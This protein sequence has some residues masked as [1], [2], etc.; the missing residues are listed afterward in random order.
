LLDGF[1]HPDGLAAFFPKL[2]S[3]QNFMD[4]PKPQ[5]PASETTTPKPENAPAKP[6]LNPEERRKIA[7]RIISIA[8][9][10]GGVVLILWVWR[11]VER[12]PRTDDA[13][14]QANVIGVAPRVHGQIIKLNVQDNQDVTEGDVLFEIDPDDYKLAL[15]NAK[16]ALA[17]LDQQIEVARAQ[18]AELKFQVK[19]AEAGVEQAKAEL[20]QASDTLQRLQPLLPK[21]FATADDVDKAQTAEKVA[22]ASLA[23]QEQRS[24]QAKT[25]LSSLATLLAQRPGTVAAVN[26]AVLDLSYCK[27]VAPFPGKVINLNISVGGYANVGV[28]VFS[29]LDT[30][31][32]YIIANFREGE[33]RHIA[34]GTSV[35]VYLLSAP[36][37]HFV[38]K[39][40]G[41]G[42]A[43]ESKDY[44]DISQG[45]PAVP[46][47]L[48]WV[49]IAQ[50]FPVRIEIENPD[51]EL[52]RMGA[53][54]EAIIKSAPVSH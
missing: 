6:P 27:V 38:G 42:W 30:R 25:S 10:V 32:W 45:V 15:E 53:S 29:L 46:R 16:A 44:I 37:R 36:N 47:E 8:A 4:D 2:K 1:I 24:N 51:P 18:D 23:A 52:F 3:I 34:P 39:V 17:G 13:T 35:D 31:H 54:A 43:V 41:I 33:L 12:H 7:G 48:N 49:H 21:G 19:A 11:I 20:K 14:A 22:M 9:I 28:P 50:R 5:T 26:R 40:Q